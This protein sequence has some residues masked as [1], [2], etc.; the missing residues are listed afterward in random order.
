M[1]DYFSIGEV[2][3]YQ[4][5]SKQT[6]I[7]YDRIGLFCPAYIDPDNGYR[8]YS[9]AQID[10]LDTILIMKKVGFSLKEIREHMRNY[11]IDSSLTALKR[12]VS[13]IEKRIEE[14][15]SIKNRLL[16]RCGQM[17]GVRLYVKQEIPV[18]AEDIPEQF[19][20]FQ[21]V[22]SPY[23]LRE[24]SVATKKCFSSAFEKKLPIYFQCGVV[25]PFENI[26]GQRYTAASYAFLP[27]EK[28]DRTDKVMALPA[29]RGVS[30]YHVG[31]YLSIGRTYEKLIR[32]CEQNDLQIVSDSYEFCIN[33]YITSRD[34]TEYITK[35]V[36]Y[37][38]RKGSYVRTKP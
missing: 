35:I 7:F 4:N 15:C 30:T 5:I 14:L 26:K 32:Y 36:F 27:I 23:D 17:E 3:K 18:V 9:S 33:D 24:I 21:E 37:V 28:T 11:T 16:H 8:Y 12:Q 1:K 13:V 29:G 2:A 6:L 10:Y 31:D 38:I 20:Y 34:E 19:L 25:V 22:E